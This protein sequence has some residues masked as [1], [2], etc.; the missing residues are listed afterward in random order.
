MTGHQQYPLGGIPRGGN[1]G[2]RKPWKGLIGC[3]GMVAS[4]MTC[5]DTEIACL[6]LLRSAVYEKRPMGVLALSEAAVLQQDVR[7]AS[8]SVAGVCV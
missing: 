4:T 7:S 8:Q 6:P 1:G 2:L 3:C 5:G